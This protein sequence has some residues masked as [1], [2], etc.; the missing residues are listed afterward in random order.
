MGRNCRGQQ[1]PRSAQQPKRGEAQHCKQCQTSD[2]S[3]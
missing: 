1:R 2:T 3:F